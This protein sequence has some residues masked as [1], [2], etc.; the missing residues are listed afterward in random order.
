[1]YRLSSK[2]VWTIQYSLVSNKNMERDLE[3]QFSGTDTCLAGSDPGFSC[4]EGR[5]GRR[6]KRGEGGG[7]SR[8]DG[9]RKAKGREGEERK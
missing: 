2:P 1:M 6:K 9:E 4:K 7:A 5:E 8:K 3:M